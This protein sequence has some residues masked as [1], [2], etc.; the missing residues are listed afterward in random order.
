MCEKI[1]NDRRI[2]TLLL[3]VWTFISSSAFYWIM[4]TDH[5]PFLQFGPNNH[6]KL[7]GVAVDTWG[8]WWVVTIYTFVSTGIAAFASDSIAPFITNTVQDHKTVYIPY[9]KGMCLL[10][11]QI[12]TTYSVVVSIIGLFVALTQVD[13]TIVRL[14]SDLI[15]NHV[16]TAYFLRGKVVNAQRYNAWQESQ[17]GRLDVIDDDDTIDVSIDDIEIS[18]IPDDKSVLMTTVSTMREDSIKPQP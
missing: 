12:F 13:F 4:V 17:K 15:I 16:T 18:N 6:T 2:I 7:F 1:F 8:K 10:I 9:S 3:A 11:I 5:S 14:L